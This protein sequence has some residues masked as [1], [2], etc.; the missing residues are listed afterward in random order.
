MMP[1]H[2]KFCSNRPPG[3]DLRGK[4]NRPAVA[5]RMSVDMPSIREGP[6]IEQLDRLL[7]RDPDA[8]EGALRARRPFARA[9]Y[10]SRRPSATISNCCAASRPISACSTISARSCSRRDTAAPRARCSSEAVRHH[11]DNPTGSRQS[12]QSVVADRRARGGACAISKPPCAPIPV[13]SMPIAAWAICWPRLGDAAGARRHRDQGFDERLSGHA[14]LIAAT[15]R[16][17]GVLLLVSAVGGNTPTASLL[18]DDVFQTTVLVTEY[19]RRRRCRCR[20][21]ISSS[22]ASA[23]RIFAPKASK[24]RASDAGANGARR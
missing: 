7:E 3:G 8:I 11:P 17:C 23:T 18:D 1:F 19:Y 9:R 21:T 4:N 20:R 6:R 24:P 13:T 10:R 12:R 22:T 2:G 14:C 15:E 5:V 16:R